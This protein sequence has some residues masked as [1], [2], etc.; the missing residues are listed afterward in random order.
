MA[1]EG[2][3][4]PVRTKIFFGAGTA[5]EQ[6]ALTSIGA[7][8]M[9][10]YN[11]VHGIPATLSGLAI[12]LSLVFDGVS[13]PLVGSLSDRTRSKLG[14]RHPWMFAAPIP[15]ALSLYFIFMPPAGLEGFWLF[16]WFTVFV[17]LLRQFMTFFHVPHLALGGELSTNYTER[18][19]IMAYNNF[20][21]WAGAAGKTWIALTFFFYA[22]PEYP[23]GLLNPD[24]Y[25]RY[26]LLASIA[27]L[28]IL[29][30]SAWF[31]RDVIPRL[32]KPPANLPKYSPLEFF[33]DMKK[34][35]T[36]PNYFWLLVAF[37]FL[38]C[39][40]GMR[41]GLN[42]YV[43]TFFWGLTS[44]Q[45]RWFVGGS[46]LAYA[47]GF[48]A[49]A[50]FHRRFDK[51][52]TIVV[53]AFLLSV[54]P[55]IP[56]TLGMFGLFLPNGH[57]LFLPLLIG[58]SAVALCAGSILNISVNSALAD[59]ADEN[60]VKYGLRQEGVLYST[61]S[62]F[63][64]V[65]NAIGTLLAGIALDLIAFPQRADPELVP[66]ETLFNL[67]L[68]DGAIATIPGLIC[69]YF[70]SRYNIDKTKFEATRAEIERRRAGAQAA[71]AEAAIADETLGSTPENLQPRP[72]GGGG[73]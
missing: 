28:V 72:S 23:R 73:T 44:E 18:S 66:Q 40:L 3:R 64:K 11:Q 48:F 52:R 32:P 39:M 50:R 46:A 2:A 35:L 25:P 51:R 65:D 9:F 69:L 1:T 20:A 47:F 19:Q 68:V 45:I 31:T 26:A 63:G 14:R 60:E 42:L 49:A 41:A 71:A 17:T 10:F 4:V 70:Y 67:A 54:V 16:V 22:T 59:I 21:G 33:R 36:N 53:T 61:R 58:I 38:S 7:Y 12:T 24:A 13:D 55:A 56:V 37:F 27:V 57:A 8:A 15:I 62:F 29:F 6:I 43:N 30:S 5:A 34:A